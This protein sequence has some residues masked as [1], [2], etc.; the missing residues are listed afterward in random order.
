MSKYQGIVCLALL[1]AGAGA[2][3]RATRTDSKAEVNPIRRVVTMLQMMQKKVIA[4]GKTEKE[5][6]DK[7]MCWCE[8]GA[9]DLE[10]A[11]DAGET[12]IPQLES[13]IK[14]IIATIA[15]LKASIAKAKGDRKAAL[16]AIAS[17]KVERSKGKAA[18]EK[19]QED[20]LT[21]IAALKKAISALEK[22]M[23]GAFLQTSTAAVLRRLVV[24]LN[25]I[26]D[27]DRDVLSS[28]LSG[29]EGYA[30]QSGEIVG[31]LKQMLDTMM[32]QLKDVSGEETQDK[33]NFELM[34]K[35]KLKLVGTLTESIE[36]WLSRLGELMVLLE[37]LK[38]DLGDTS[39]TLGENKKFLADMDDIFAKKKAEWALRQ[40]MRA[41]ELAALADTIRILN[42]D[43]SLE[44][45]KKTI[46][47]ASLLQLTVGSSD[48]RK[49]AAEALIVANGHGRARDHRLGLIMMAL[50][51]GKVSFVK[52]IAMIDDMI[53]LLGEEQT[54]DDAKKTYCEAQ[55]DKT[56]D[57]LKELEH[58]IEDLGKA[59]ADAKEAV[60]TLTE[61]IAALEKGIKQLDK[62][63]AEATETRKEEHE[64][65][66]QG[67]AANHAA[68]DILGIA[69]NRL[70]KFYNPKLYKAPP[71]R[72]LTEAERISV[73]NG[74]TL[75]PTAP[76]AGI[77]GTGIAVFAQVAMTAPPQVIVGGCAGTQ[78]GCCPGSTKAA[79]GP[80]GEGCEEPA[81]GL[82]VPP[83]SPG[84]IPETVHVKPSPPPET[85]GA[86][87]KQG[88]ANSGVMAMMAELEA[89][90]D[91]DIQES[92][93][94]EEHAQA[95]YEEYIGDSAA[96]R[97]DDV[98]SLADKVAA[99]AANEV[100]L[101]K[102][103]EEEKDK[104]KREMATAETLKDLHVACDWLL[105]NHATRKEAR[106]GEVEALQNAKAV[107]SGADYAF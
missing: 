8:G 73:N 14:E 7:F 98:K 78:Y 35:A 1:L 96:K 56:E 48:L 66:V 85:W 74:G 71:K 46:P 18:H 17:L 2:S 41:Q 30:P 28:F 10:S 21:N 94:D 11:I 60:A 20:L 43:D 51:G 5:L 33:L 82:V 57:D 84:G 12:K 93:V 34:L 90:L 6:F 64:D 61:E 97:A 39:T 67:M 63:V 44:L 75:A 72:E 26:K 101:Q 29:G 22:G 42:D 49:R 38:E 55:I 50:K 40:K 23:A 9:A 37:Q 83:A 103:I 4:E 45:F 65:F 76:P 3:T 104:T 16:S 53:K 100:E 89:D 105:E 107:L 19:D 27:A 52:V 15:Q 36:K 31:I 77:A 92:T 62:D 91:K 68:K 69:K 102:M 87:K 24:S 79:S 95:E 99:K 80:G 88:D 32:G 59:I 13:K 86:Y 106:A 70:A 25:N 47:S 81:T 58:D 54:D